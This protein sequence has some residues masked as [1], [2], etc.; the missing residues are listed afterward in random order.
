MIAVR[1]WVAIALLV[2]FYVMTVV[3]LAGILVAGF[4]AGWVLRWIAIG[5]AVALFLAVL[6][7]FAARPPSPTGVRLTEA[8]AP[9]LWHVV[10]GLAALAG[11]REPDEIRLVATPRVRV[12]EEAGLLGLRGGWRTLEIGAPLLRA[13]TVTDLAATA[14]H[15]LS[16]LTR[17]HSGPVAVAHR[18]QVIVN[19]TAAAVRNPFVRAMFLAYAGLYTAVVE[20]IDRLLDRE[21]DGTLVAVAGRE[22]AAEALLRTALVEAAWQ[23]YRQEYVD[24]LRERGYVAADMFDGF[25]EFMAVRG[26]P[27][28]PADAQQRVAAI[29]AGPSAT[30]TPDIRPALDLVSEERDEVLRQLEVGAF[31]ET[32]FRVL[33]WHELTAKAA[34]NAAQLDANRLLEAAGGDARAVLRLLADGRLPRDAS[35]TNALRGLVAVTLLDA[36]A[37]TWRHSWTGPAQ[38]VDLEGNPVDRDLASVLA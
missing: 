3:L 17:R 15:Q 25:A 5:A 28:L 13:L 11:T 23:Q 9:E 21:A 22:G 4:F 10:R 27:A 37:A 8:R 14:G 19:A 24:P 6:Q 34:T 32:G 18:G 16:R 35:T 30:V 2:G 33:P 36:G 7:V 38:L 31:H 29:A 20:P 26:A 1:A 12:V